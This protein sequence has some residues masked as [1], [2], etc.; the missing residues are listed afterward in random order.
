[1]TAVCATP[2]V[3]WTRVLSYMDRR[4]RD[5]GYVNNCGDS[6]MWAKPATAVWNDAHDK[7]YVVK[8]MRAWADE[9]EQEHA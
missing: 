8:Q 4:V 6:E 9:W 2:G 1:M 3:G 5:M 7:D